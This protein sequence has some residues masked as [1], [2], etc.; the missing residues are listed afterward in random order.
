M[1]EL[2]GGYEE[3]STKQTS[4]YLPAT[5]ADRHGT[6]RAPVS[7]PASAPGC[8]SKDVAQT[9]SRITFLYLKEL[10]AI[11][12]VKQPRVADVSRLVP[13]PQ[14]LLHTRQMLKKK[15]AWAVMQASETTDRMTIT[16]R[17]HHSR[18]GCTLHFPL[19]CIVLYLA[20]TQGLQELPR[21]HVWWWTRHV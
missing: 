20:A 13:R 3:Q 8:P 4:R 14:D 21:T 9:G 2:V 19:T 17:A 18:R 1:L 7:E 5:P 6:L 12:R 10:G 11:H 16:A 15:A